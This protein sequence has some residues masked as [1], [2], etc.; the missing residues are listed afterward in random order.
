MNSHILCFSQR[1]LLTMLLF[2]GTLLSAQ[3]HTR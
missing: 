2:G 3:E 1:I